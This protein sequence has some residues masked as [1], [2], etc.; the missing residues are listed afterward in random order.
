MEARRPVKSDHRNP[1]ERWR[2]LGPRGGGG[3]RLS[4][5]EGGEGEAPGPW[6]V[7]FRV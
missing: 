4:A 1:G 6:S 2:G 3:G 7:N 5:F